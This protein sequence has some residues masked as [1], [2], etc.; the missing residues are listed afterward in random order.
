[1]QSIKIQQKF[2]Q[3]RIELLHRKNDSQSRLL[4]YM[5]NKKLQLTAVTVAQLSPKKAKVF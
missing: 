1:M 2:R 4:L 3:L 5:L